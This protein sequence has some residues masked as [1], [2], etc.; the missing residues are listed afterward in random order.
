MASPS[1]SSGRARHHAARLSV[2]AG[3]TRVKN[4]P[5]VEADFTRIQAAYYPAL[6]EGGS[7]II[8]HNIFMAVGVM[9][10][11]K[12]DPDL[13]CIDIP[14]ITNGRWDEE[15]RRFVEGQSGW[16]GRGF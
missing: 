11:R 10:Q 7:L 9:A 2:G 16:P 15:T 14:I 1:P 12:N 5:L 8:V 3:L 4:P 13:L 6:R